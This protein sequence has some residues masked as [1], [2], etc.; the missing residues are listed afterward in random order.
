MMSYKLVTK[1]AFRRDSTRCPVCG[2]DFD[3]YGYQA[4]P[5]FVWR[6]ENGHGWYYLETVTG[7]ESGAGE[8]GWWVES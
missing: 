8:I 6:C 7:P 2:D 5:V 4:K 1:T 3:D